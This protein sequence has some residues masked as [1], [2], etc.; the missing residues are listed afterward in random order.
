[1]REKREIPR[2]AQRINHNDAIVER[3]QLFR[4]SYFQPC[5]QSDEL[6]NHTYSTPVSLLKLPSFP[7][8]MMA[9]ANFNR[10]SDGI[11]REIF[12]SYSFVD[13][14]DEVGIGL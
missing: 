14:W 9:E 10:I 7:V 12:Q 8:A 4:V 6:Y 11:L 5:A 3:K 2:H 13:E 1:M